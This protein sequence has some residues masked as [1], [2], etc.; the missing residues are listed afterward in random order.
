VNFDELLLALNKIDYTGP[1]VIEREA[2]DNR[3]TDIRSAIEFMQ[4][5][6][7]A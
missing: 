6:Q 2:S 3:M 1:L 5:L 7:S 4:N